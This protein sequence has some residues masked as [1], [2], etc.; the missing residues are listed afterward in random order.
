MLEKMKETSEDD[1]TERGDMFKEFKME[2]VPHMKAEEK[3]FYSVLKEN[4]EAKE[5]ALEAIEEHH[6]AELVFKELDKM[7]KQDESWHAKLSVF[8][9]MIKHHIQE[10]EGKVFE[11]AEKYIP[12]KEMQTI[13]EDF[14]KE[15]EKLKEQPMV[16]GRA[17]STAK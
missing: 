11:D 4:E 8:Q 2:L 6:A 10:E 7:S 3:V 5:D 14:Q 16:R 9:E 1:Y 13:A 12:H 17:K 15:K